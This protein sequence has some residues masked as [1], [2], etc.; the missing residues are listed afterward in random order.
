MDRVISPFLTTFFIIIIGLSLLTGETTYPLITK[1]DV[2]CPAASSWIFDD[3]NTIAYTEIYTP[4]ADRKPKIFLDISNFHKFT[5][6]EQKFIFYHE[7]GHATGIE[8]E[9]GADTYAINRLKN[10]GLDIDTINRLC[11]TLDDAVDGKERCISMKEKLNS[12]L[13]GK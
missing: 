7:C 12:Y 10:Y 11:K 8:S 2:R 1:K 9:I 3:L 6:L 13:G 5:I 4:E